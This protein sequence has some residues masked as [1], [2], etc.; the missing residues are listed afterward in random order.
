MLGRGN[1]TYMYEKKG[2]SSLPHHRPQTCSLLS[3]SDGPWEVISSTK[4]SLGD[5]A[6]GL[7]HCSH[8]SHFGFKRGRWKG[9]PVPLK[10]EWWK[11]EGRTCATQHFCIKFK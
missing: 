3:L 7:L 2:I 1:G 5:Q 10:R 4:P 8:H 9:A 11:V 6:L